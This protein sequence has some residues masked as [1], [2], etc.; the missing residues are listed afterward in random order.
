MLSCSDGWN[1]PCLH[2]LCILWLAQVSYPQ[3]S[4][5]WRLL[6]PTPGLCVLF[7]VSP[8]P[9]SALGTEVSLRTGV[10]SWSPLHSQLLA[11]CLTPYRC[12]VRQATEICAISKCDLNIIF[13][14]PPV[15]I[16]LFF[17]YIP[18]QMYFYPVNTFNIWQMS[19]S[20][21]CDFG[22]Y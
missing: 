3:E 11:E 4:L 18:L 8:S 1:C 20:W 13:V 16:N 10:V 22:Y 2:H 14:S 17:L 9:D 19:C 5:P 15:R 12:P 7:T 6:H 21:L